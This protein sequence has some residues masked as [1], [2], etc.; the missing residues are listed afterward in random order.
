MV[1]GLCFN[2]LSTEH[3]VTIYKKLTKC[4]HYR[5]ARHISF[6]CPRRTTRSPSTTSRC[7]PVPR[8]RPSPTPLPSL[9]S[10]LLRH[11]LTSTSPAGLILMST[12]SRSPP[13]IRDRVEFFEPRS[14]FVWIMRNRPYTNVTH[15]AEAFMVRFGLDQSS[16][17]VSHHNP[18]DFLVSI[19]DRDVFKEVVHPDSFTHGGRQF[20]L[21]RWSLRDQATR[22]MMRYYVQMCLEGLP[23][24]LWLGSFAAVG[25]APC[26]M[27]RNTQEGGKHLKSSSCWHG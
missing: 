19:L 3:K 26:T 25:H 6:A 15:V 21:H 13:E 7:S 10:L 1:D 4:W 27:Q 22:A 17:Q 18:T 2:C 9:T 16:I 5:R 23:L 11:W 24:H 8:H 12:T 20:R 14:I